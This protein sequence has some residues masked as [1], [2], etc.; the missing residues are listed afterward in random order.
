MLLIFGRAEHRAGACCLCRQ[1]VRSSPMGA[2]RDV[3]CTNSTSFG[4]FEAR[5]DAFLKHKDRIDSM[6]LFAEIYQ[7]LYVKKHL[8]LCKTEITQR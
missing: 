3:G 5:C 6:S 8:Y 1:E 4:L 2:V 7:Q